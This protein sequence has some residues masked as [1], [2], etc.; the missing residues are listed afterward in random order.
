MKDEQDNPHERH[1]DS[2]DDSITRMRCEYRIEYQHDTD[3]SD[4]YII[5]SRHRLSSKELNGSS[6]QGYAALSMGEDFSRILIMTF[7]KAYEAKKYEDDIYKRWE[8]SGFFNPD[9]LDG[10]PYAIMMPPPNVTGILHLGHALE[11]TLMDVMARY[12]RMRGKRVLLLPGTDHAAVATQA[13]VEKILK[14]QGVERPREEFGRELLIEKIREFAEQSKS[15]ILTQIRKMGTSCDWSRLAYTFDEARSQAVNDVFVRMYRDGLVYRGY[16]V[17]NWS[18][19]GQ[20][21]CSDDELVYVERPATLYTFIYSKDFPIPIATTRPETKLGDTAVA[22][23]PDDPRYKQYIGETYTVDVGAQKPL[24]IKVI[25]DPGVDPNFGTGALG[26]TPAH[27]PI[28]FDMYERQRE[29]GDP[30]ELSQVIGADGRMTSAAGVAYAGL[31]TQEAREKF[32]EM[33]KKGG[34]LQKEEEITQR[35]GTS[36]RFGDIVEALPLTQWFV[37]VKREIPDRGKT[38]KDLMRDAVAVGHHGDPQQKIHIT[39]ER[40][41]ATY[42]QWID[43]LRDWCISRQI[44][45]GHRIPVWYR[46]AEVY[47]C[48]EPPSGDGWTQDPDTLDTWFSSGLWTFSTLGW[49]E[50]TKDF[51]TFH[52]T[53]WMQMGHEILFFW[54]ARMILMST[55]ALDQIPFRD[56]YIHG[57]LR[58]EQ[59]R[60]FSKSL[61][62]GIDPIDVIADYGCDALRM[63]VISGITPG[64]DARFYTEK[65]ERARNLVNKL[66]NISRFMHTKI[67]QPV[68]DIDMPAPKTL[69]DEWICSE[70]DMTVRSV[71][72]ALDRYDFSAGAETLRSFT[73]EKLA[74]WYLEISK[75]EGEKGHILNAILNTVLKLW[76]PFMPFVTEAIWQELYGNASL[77]MTEHFPE[78]TSSVDPEIKAFGT[79]I[80][81]V[82]AIRSVRA[83]YRIEP[84][85]KVS[86]YVGGG[87]STM[88]LEDNRAII[89]ALGRIETLLIA[90]SM[91]KPKNGAGIVVGDIEAFVDLSGIIDI[92]K[93]KAR[94][95]KEIDT[96]TPYLSSLQDKLTNEAFLQHAPTEV[97]DKERKKLVDA[98]ER[99]KKIITQLNFF[100]R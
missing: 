29:I 79:I 48:T 58:D 47:C 3:D 11:N 31:T 62:N 74:D 49:P 52:P 81:F 72:D 77:L 59:G 82:S 78:T 25:A 6:Y 24:T 14:E 2:D 23:N 7:D 39:P 86:V 32:V 45:W 41:E 63:S 27:S 30:I 76:H 80:D 98:E 17:V 37:A 67:P 68:S 13:K 88:I 64:N 69:A 54:M 53:Q 95:Q 15:T 55:Y 9:N 70:L 18:V 96:L 71:R 75:I 87:K 97:V 40:F 100:D 66:W 35:V 91:E 84:T 44:W 90:E 46:E 65:I 43:H 51:E 61:G 21:T 8:E 16:R 85:K 57:I 38:L 50:K 99:I 89:E 42:F 10:E 12:Q 22:V 83:D 19:K 93:E 33:L 34:L 73:W 60:K 92:E 1:S 56:V 94:L 28:D 5:F 4:D 20:S 36:D 26:V